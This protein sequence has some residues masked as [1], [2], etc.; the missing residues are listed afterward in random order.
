MFYYTDLHIRWYFWEDFRLPSVNKERFRN[1]FQYLGPKLIKI[2]SKLG[3]KLPEIINKNL[4]LNFFAD[5]YMVD[6]YLLQI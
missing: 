4:K 3:P 1:Y 6:F 2:R 5:L